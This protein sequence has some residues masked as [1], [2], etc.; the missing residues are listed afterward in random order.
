MDTPTPYSITFP[1]SLEDPRTISPAFSN[2]SQSTESVPNTPMFSSP[3]LSSSDATSIDSASPCH[4]RSPSTTHTENDRVLSSSASI[5]YLGDREEYQFE[6]DTPT[7]APPPIPQ[8]RRRL[9]AATVP[10]PQK[11]ILNADLVH[12]DT[13]S[14]S[15]VVQVLETKEAVT[16]SFPFP[17]PL[18]AASST[19]YDEGAYPPSTAST[20]CFG[21]EAEHHLTRPSVSMPASPISTPCRAQSP[22]LRSRWS[23]E[24]TLREDLPTS[25]TTSTTSSKPKLRLGILG[26]KKSSSSSLNAPHRRLY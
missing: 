9:R 4:S 7:P 21:E 6:R 10:R 5:V 19:T 8:V 23:M 22:V 14:L 24:S 16:E 26:L 13:D 17:P 11:F 3:T 1:P 12:L 18:S 2:Y 25:V 20:E 15:N